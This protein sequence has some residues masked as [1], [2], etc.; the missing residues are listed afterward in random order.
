MIRQEDRRFRHLEWKIGLFIAIALAGVAVAVVLFGLQKDFFT[1]KY[2]LH[3]TVDRGT[4]FTKGMPVKLSGFRIGR[5]TSIA[6]NDQAMVDISAE[7]DSKYSKWIRSDSTVKLVKEGLVGDY[8]VEVAV[9]SSDKPELKD[10]DAII[11]VKT[12]AL[13]ELAD[14]IADKVKPVLAEISD[15]ISYINNPDGDIKKS[16]RNLEQLTRNLEGTRQRTDDLLISANT[17][18]DRLSNRATL[19]LDTSYKRIDALDLAPALARVNNS[20]DTIDKRLPALLEKADKSLENISK[21]SADTRTL[22]EKAFPKIPGILSQAEDV[23]L[24]T[25]RL[26]NSIQ[27]IWLFRDGPSPAAGQTFIRGDSYE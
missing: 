3:F 24:S 21:I 13:D 2:N 27:N 12:K 20:L 8:I 4:G 16:I 1:K 5:I 26:V 14:E 11:Y 15:I 7:L 25:D 17:N 22:S 18:I 23:L 9:G 6:L 10:S 19:L